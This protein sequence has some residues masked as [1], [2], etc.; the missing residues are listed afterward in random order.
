M[1]SLVDI[2]YG[3]ADMNLLDMFL[4]DND[5]STVYIYIHGGG[6]EGGS[7]KMGE[8]TPIYYTDR[9]IAFASIEY[10]MYPNAKFPEYI[11][12][13]ANAVKYIQDNFNFKNIFIGGSSA[14][15]Y[16]SMMLYFNK[17]YLRQA[18]IDTSLIKGYVFDAGQ[19][20]SHFNYLRYDKKVDGRCVLVDEGAPI[21]FLRKDFTPDEPHV[22][23]ICS[24]R[25]MTN[26]LNQ[27]NTLVTAMKQFKFPVERLLFKVYMNETHCS[28]CQKDYYLEDTYNFIKNA[29]GE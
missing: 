11:I 1:K 3:E 13:C 5:T 19:P 16:L 14:G 25:D 29:L 12:D 28:Y 9:G 26:R 20:T 21:F 24:E 27:T 7:R 23:F 17:E 18:N 6:I 8:K 22:F 2:R 4:P 15:G 10:R